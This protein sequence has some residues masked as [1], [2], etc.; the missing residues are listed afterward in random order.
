MIIL[1]TM[2]PRSDADYSN[3]IGTTYWDDPFSFFN[4]GFNVTTNGNNR[5]ITGAT[6]RLLGTWSACLQ[7][8]FSYLGMEIVSI[9]AAESRALA[10]PDCNKMATRKTSLRIIT[11]YTIA[12]FTVSFLVPANH[13]FINGK[14]TSEGASSLFVIAVVE[15]GIPAAAHFFNAVFL[16]SALTSSST[17]LYVASRVLHTLALRDQTG[18]EFI[19]RRLRRCRSGVPVRALLISGVMM[20]IA[21]MGS[22]GTSNVRLTQ[23]SSTTTISFLIVYIIICAAYLGFFRRLQEAKEYG[24]TSQTQAATYDRD[25]QRYPY[26]SHGQ[27]LKACYGIVAC[28]ILLI[29]NGFNSFLEEPFNS[30]TF[31]PSYI[32]IPIFLLLAAGY[33]FWKHS[34][35]L[36]EWGP[37]KSN[38]LSNCI[39]ASSGPRKGRLEFPDDAITLDNFRA[40]AE[41]LWVWVK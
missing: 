1:E 40:F 24:N 15:A 27:W 33:K 37:E 28:T 30:D 25:D 12:L 19:T 7:A 21:Y 34:F 16:F 18:P 3:P 20:L 32:S 2:Q 14:H 31:V 5:V 9:P 11:L 23:I 4:S 22:T 41:W 38:D 29:F 8:M 26:K 39:R 10:D 35:N 13:P 17:N 36:S 6:G